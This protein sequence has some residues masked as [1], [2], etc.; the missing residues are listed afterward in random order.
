MPGSC[1]GQAREIFNEGLH[2]PAV[3]YQRAY[4]PNT[5]LERLIGANSRTPELVLGDIRGQL[6]AD[7]LGERRLEELA[8]KFSKRELLACMAAAAA[9]LSSAAATPIP[10]N[11]MCNTRS[12]PAAPERARAKTVPGGG[13][14]GDPLARDPERVLADPR[15]GAVSKDAAERDYGVILKP[16]GRTWL[17]DVAATQTRRTQLRADRAKTARG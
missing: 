1:S 15:E 12:S 17:L 5:D 10:A 16:A 4:R 7:R 3:R 6:G 8:G 11:P 9:P 13:G 2:L 14:H